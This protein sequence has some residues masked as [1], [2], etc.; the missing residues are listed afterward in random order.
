MATVTEP[1]RDINKV[2]EMREALT[3]ERDKMLF[4]LGINSGLRISDL[5][6]L[7]VDD[8]KPMMELR[9]QKQAS[10]NAL[11]YPSQYMRCYVS[12]H[13]IASIGYSQVVLAMVISRPPKHGEK[14]R[15]HPKS[16][17]L[18][19]SVLT[20]CVKHLGIMRIAKVC[21]SHT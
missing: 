17:V 15:Q 7:T 10:S 13:P 14:S 9:E 12:T 3:N 1:I 16:A 19:T 20:L 4:T 8:V 11:P 2:N 6:G 21:Q 18:K 5:V